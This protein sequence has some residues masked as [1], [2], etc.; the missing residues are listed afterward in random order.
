MIVEYVD[1]EVEVEVDDDHEFVVAIVVDNR[2]GCYNQSM[3]SL[4]AIVG[5][6]MLIMLLCIA[7]ALMILLFY[8]CYILQ[9]KIICEIAS[10][11]SRFFFW[12]NIIY[13]EFNC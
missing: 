13:N 10:F 1:V 9:M 2:N 3:T 11:F 8:C 6:W 12:Y 5:Y 7:G 4:I